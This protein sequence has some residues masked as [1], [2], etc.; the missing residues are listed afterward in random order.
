MSL[1]INFGTTTDPVNCPNKTYTTIRTITGKATEAENLLNPS[2]VIDYDE[3]MLP[4]NYCEITDW[5]RFYFCKVVLENG[6]NMRIICTTDPIKTFWDSIK[7]VPM[8]IVRSTSFGKPTYV[9]DGMLPID[10]ER[11]LAP[12]I[13]Y[14]DTINSAPYDVINTL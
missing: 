9:Q 11:T 1:T 8:T 13:I 2:F 14:F 6:N 5:N 3:K 7:I 10:E 4:C 12:K